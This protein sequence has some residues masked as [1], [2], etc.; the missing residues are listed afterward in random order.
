MVRENVLKNCP[1]TV[2]DINN[3]EILF[4]PNLGSL[5]G[6]T[7]RQASNV[8]TP[9]A[10]TDLPLEIID[11]CRDVTLCCDLM[12]VNKTIFLVTISRQIKFGTGEVLINRQGTTILKGI[13][14]VCKLYNGRGMRVRVTL[15]D[16]EFDCLGPALGAKGIVLN[17]ASRN[18]HVPEIERYIRTV[19]ER[20]RCMYNSVPFKQFPRMMIAEMVY[21]S[22]FWL[23]SIPAND[24]VS[25]RLSPRSIMVGS[26]LDYHRHCRLEFGSYVQVHEEHDNTMATRTVGAIALRPTG[27]AQG[28]F[29]FMSLESGRKLNRNHWTELPMPKE[30]IDRV[31][32]IARQTGSDRGL[33]FGNRNGDLDD[34]EIEQI[35]GV[36][37]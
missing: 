9:F 4:G 16:G 29:Y 1:I 2:E 15:M 10:S 13:E 27:N 3:A 17:G 14:A 24:G 35:E 20:T 30:V 37:S 36:D 19:K 28:G 12:F 26:V 18:E 11:R 22:I 6:K 31:Q 34:P 8:V 7:T 23:N 32:V 21:A 5:K 33:A 25:D